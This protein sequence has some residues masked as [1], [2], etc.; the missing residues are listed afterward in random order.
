MSNRAK[1]SLHEA[2]KRTE[3]ITWCN[4]KGKN[5]G[6]FF[7][8]IEYSDEELLEWIKLCREDEKALK[9]APEDI[10][11]I[12]PHAFTEAHFA[13]F[14]VELPKRILK[15]AC[16]NQVCTEC[17]NAREPI[18]ETINTDYNE[19]EYEGKYES[20]YFKQSSQNPTAMKNR[21][22]TA[23]RRIVGWTKCDCN[24]PFEAG[25]VLDPFFGAGTTAVAAEQLGLKWVGIELNEEYIQIANKRLAKYKNTKMGEFS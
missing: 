17:G 16:P 10:F 13:T 19:T 24:A 23:T 11:R 14:P 20:G 9:V 5:P 18:T 6:D 22:L 12:N 25:M 15:C 3:D 21:I 2:S 8:D 1:G 7:K 4:T